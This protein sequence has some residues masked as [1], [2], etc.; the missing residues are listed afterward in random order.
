MAGRP[1]TRARAIAKAVEAG[2]PPPVILE[3]RPEMSKFGQPIHPPKVDPTRQF[4]K[5]GDKKD[6]VIVDTPVE[7]ASIEEVVRDLKRSDRMSGLTDLA[8]DAAERILSLVIT[9]DTKDHLKL[10]GLQQQ[11]LSSVLTVQTRVDGSSFRQ[12][13][14]DTLGDML[15]MIKSEMVSDT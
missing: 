6:R 10:L 15:T 8:L 14:S 9:L 12:H 3:T 2:E 7:A 13:E 4:I 11:T 1:L 5:S